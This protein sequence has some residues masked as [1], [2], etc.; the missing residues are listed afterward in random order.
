MREKLTAEERKEFAICEAVIARG[1]GKLYYEIGAALFKIREGRLYRETHSNFDDYSQDRWDYTRRHA[2]RLIQSAAVADNLRPIGLI[3]ATESQAR[4]LVG[5]TAEQQKD[6]MEITAAVAPDGVIT[7]EELARVRAHRYPP[8]P[9]AVDVG[10]VW[11]SLSCNV[12][13]VSFNSGNNEW[14]TPAEFIEAAR[15]VMGAIDLDP[16]SSDV[17]NQFVEAT[18]YY[19]AKENGLDKEWAGRVWMNPPY[20]DD[21]VGRFIEKLLAHYGNRDITQ[22]IVLVNNATETAWSQSLAAIARVKCEPKGRIKYL[23]DTGKPANTPLQGQQFFYLGNQADT[24]ADVFK[25]FGVIWN[26]G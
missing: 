14:Y 10:D 4:E 9:K 3:P 7:A 19:T 1:Q 25:Q 17:A 18:T 11:Q 6:V 24:F 8:E 23:D 15:E 5:L 20:S 13:H 2:D 12:P 22:A 26:K 21:L 16:A